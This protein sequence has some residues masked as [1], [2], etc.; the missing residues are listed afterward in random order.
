MPVVPVRQLGHVPQIATVVRIQSQGL[1]D[2]LQRTNGIV[3]HRIEPGQ[4]IVG[5]GLIRL[6]PVLKQIIWA[7][8]IRDDRNSETA[9]IA[10]WSGTPYLDPWNLHRIGPS[11][12]RHSPMGS[13]GYVEAG[14]T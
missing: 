11:Q 5:F 1:F 10:V 13:K 12:I 14:F 3:R 7:L 2:L 9:G 4:L 8:R 6:N